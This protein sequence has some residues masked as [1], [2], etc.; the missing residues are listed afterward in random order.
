MVGDQVISNVAVPLSLM[1]ATDC[2]S[3]R[4]DG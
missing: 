4:G 1:R 2:I 3:G